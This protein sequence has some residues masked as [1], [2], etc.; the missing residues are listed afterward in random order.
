M[1][2]FL[3]KL[4]SKHRVNLLDFRNQDITHFAR[5]NFKDSS[6]VA[7]ATDFR[8]CERNTVVICKKDIFGLYTIIEF[9]PVHSIRRYCTATVKD[10]F[11]IQII[12][13][14]GKGIWNPNRRNNIP[15]ITN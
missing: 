3:E 1:I 4:T 9:Q 13:S 7:S 6:S 10:K 11:R 2:Y 12:S 15:S 5:K 8:K 14:Q